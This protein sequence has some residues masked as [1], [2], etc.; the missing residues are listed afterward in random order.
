M[1]RPF[2][3]TFDSAQSTLPSRSAASLAP[4]SYQANINRQKTKK[5]VDAKPGNYGG[6]DWGDD[7][8]DGYSDPPPPPPVPKITGLRQPGQ[9]VR[10]DT[11]DK[12]TYGELSNLPKD[13]QDRST[14]NPPLLRQSSFTKDDE[15]RAFSSSPS[16]QGGSANI[17]TA[18]TT[19]TQAVTPPLSAKASQRKQVPSQVADSSAP[20]ADGRTSYA[21]SNRSSAHTSPDTRSASGNAISNFPMPDATA[22]L[23]SA[24]LSPQVRVDFPLGRKESPPLNGGP[25]PSQ[26]A[27]RKASLSQVAVPDDTNSA[28][29]ASNSPVMKALPFIRPADIYKR[30]E[31]ERQRGSESLDS[32]RPS[33]D[34]VAA[35]NPDR[36]PSPALTQ[37]VAPTVPQQSETAQH[38]RRDRK[39]VV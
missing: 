39:S 11:G 1:S 6:D 10:K 15:R 3:D 34:S 24:A 13:G 27:P 20:L 18:P 36:Q 9:A 29:A 19:S 37:T 16:H 30:L 23:R 38:G 17:S 35:A 32:S 12:K 21:E 22:P 4:I 28:S 31:E 33:L 8:D 7:Y 5:W 2:P 25:Q 14:T 26:F